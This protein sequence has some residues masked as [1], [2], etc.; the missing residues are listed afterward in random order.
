M[1]AQEAEEKEAAAKEI[2]AT[3]RP[4][5]ALCDLKPLIATLDRMIA[6]SRAF[7]ARREALQIAKHTSPWAE[8]VSANAREQSQASR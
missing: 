2:A 5:L 7:R 6:E 1:S 4:S 8:A 3:I